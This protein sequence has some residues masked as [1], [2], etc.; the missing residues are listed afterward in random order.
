VRLSNNNFPGIFQGKTRGKSNTSTKT[1]LHDRAFFREHR[2]HQEVAY[3]RRFRKSQSSAT[4]ITAAYES[5]LS[6][7]R[8]TS[9]MGDDNAE[10]SQQQ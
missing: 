2:K 5:L 4:F 3:L 9:L 7:F 10:N 8:I 6:T 1:K